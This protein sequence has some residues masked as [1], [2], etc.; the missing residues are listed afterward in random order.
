MKSIRSTLLFLLLTALLAAPLSARGLVNG[1][2]QRGGQQ[3]S[4]SGQLSTTKV[5]ASY[6]GALVTVYRAGTN[7]LATIYSNVGGTPLG[8]PLTASNTGFY[9]FWTD[10][11]NVDLQFSGGGISTPFTLTS[12]AP[13]IVSGT[14]GLFVNVAD[15]PYSAVGDGSDETSKISAAVATI[16]TAAGGTLWFPRG[17]TGVYGVRTV[18]GQAHVPYQTADLFPDPLFLFY[19]LYGITVAGNGARIEDLTK[20]HF[21]ISAGNLTYAAGT[22]TVVTSYAHGLPNGAVITIAAATPIE[23]NGTYRITVTSPTSFTYVPTGAPASSPAGG[24]P[25]A[26]SDGTMMRFD[27][28]NNIAVRGLMFIGEI[29]YTAGGG[30]D[31][32][33]PHGL[34]FLEIT[35]G[36]RGADISANFLGGFAALTTQQM[37]VSGVSISS[38]TRT[39]GRAEAISVGHPFESGQYVTVLG[40]NQP[41]YNGTFQIVKASANQFNYTI[42]GSPASPATGTITASGASESQRSSL[43]RAQLSTDHV[44]RG[45]F[46]YYSGDQCDINLDA[47]TGGRDFMLIGARQ[48]DIRVKSTDQQGASVLDQISGVGNEG[49]RVWVNNRHSSAQMTSSPQITLQWA[50]TTPAQLR[51]VHLMF[52]HAANATSPAVPNGHSVQIVKL[53]DSGAP[54]STGRGHM[55]DGLEISGVMEPWSGKNVID[56]LGGFS[57]PDIVRNIRFHDISSTTATGTLPT[58]GAIN[59]FAGNALQGTMELANI[60]IPNG[61][62]NITNAIANPTSRVVMRNVYARD[63]NISTADTSPQDFFYCVITANTNTSYI[64]KRVSRTYIGSSSVD[65][66]PASASV[67]GYDFLSSASLSG[68]RVF[69]AGVLGIAGGSNGLVIGQ[70]PQTAAPGASTATAAAGAGVTEG[71]HSI[72]VT[73]VTA[74]GETDAGTVSNS[75]NATG[76]NHQINLT[77][78][79]IGGAAVTDRKIYMSAAGNDAVGPWLYVGAVGD[80]V[81]ATYTINTAD[82]GLGA[83]IPSTNTTAGMEYRLTGLQIYANN[84]AA[85]AGGLVAGDVYRSGADPDILRVVH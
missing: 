11:A 7:I 83:A 72:K 79:P 26:V 20:Y 76:A 52:D 22:A 66:A 31:Y 37:I 62:I 63:L 81:T 29:K 49:I 28:C 70:L 38:L 39:G 41:E 51:D 40:A 10:E 78:V 64:N 42:S 75:V 60:Y 84:A 1:W 67:Y 17:S 13:T 4:T 5:Q 6:P 48:V 45:F 27:A 23:Y 58:S 82:G 47:N 18:P 68:N 50:D 54:D 57:S 2:A 59:F 80:N 14:S 34:K 73:Y 44:E 33:S 85:L 74:A 3:V 19:G 61:S 15:P 8:N 77:G 56:M 9:V 30:P 46:T 12:I 55:I 25:Q 35:D 36:S 21:L 53:D 16:N 71:T 65:S 69:R 43:I 32:T 24:T